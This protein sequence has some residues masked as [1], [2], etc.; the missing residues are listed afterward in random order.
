MYIFKR[1]RF[2]FFLSLPLGAVHAQQAQTDIS[3][4]V[5]QEQAVEIALANNKA[6]AAARTTIAQAQA[7]SRQAGR[8][9]NPLLNV[10]YANDFAFNNEGQYAYAIGLRQRF[11]ITNRLGLLKDISRDEITLAETEI[12]N[13]ERVLIQ[14]VESTYLALAEAD[15]QLKLREELIALNQQFAEFVES[16]ISQGEASAV[17]ANQIKIA[18]Y[19]VEQEIRRLKNQQ[20]QY[21]SNLR[22]LLGM[23]SRIALNY[24]KE[25]SLPQS[26][27][28]LPAMDTSMLEN[29]PE[30][31]LKELLYQIADKRT[32]LARAERWGDIA[33]EIFFEE[34]NGV[35]EPLGLTNDRYLGIGVS[36]PLP[37]VNQNRGGIDA[38][39][40][41][42][43]Q[44]KLEREAVSLQIENRA[45]LLRERALQLY[46]QA[47]HYEANITELVDSNLS[48]MNDAYAAGQIDLRDVFRSQEQ[49]L[50]I[51]SANLAILRDYEQTL[52]NWEAATASNLSSDSSMNETI[53]HDE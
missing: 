28:E 38:S 34:D 26:A 9:D 5:T 49:Q 27:P 14:E 30:Y 23:N 15:A 13:Q 40:A 18:L 52:I 45:E 19:A 29:H 25:F 41:F 3:A 1:L 20:A 6:L 4:P 50:K 37:I 11:P 8:L 22:Q 2:I 36:I 43:Q 12:R 10:E 31:Q 39:R 53:S 46:Q 33:V 42:R 24:S 17:D 21:Y 48:E 47:A 51:Q 32:D 44:V 35:D 16:R 7:Q